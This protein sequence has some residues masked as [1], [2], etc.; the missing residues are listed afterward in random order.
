[1]GLVVRRAD[2]RLD[3]WPVLAGETRWVDH[4]SAV[5][6]EDLV[7]YAHAFR[8]VREGVDRT[9]DVLLWKPSTTKVAH[10]Y[11]PDEWAEVVSA[12]REWPPATVERV[13]RRRRSRSDRDR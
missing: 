4:S 2:A 12:E 6:G 8:R 1:M 7:V 9:T 11:H 3:T 13:P 5:E 10:R